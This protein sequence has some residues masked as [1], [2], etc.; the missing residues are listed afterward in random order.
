MSIPVPR[1][2]I[3]LLAPARPP[4]WAAASMPSARPETM[5]SP[6][7]L[8]ARE[9]LRVALALGTRVAASDDRERRARGQLDATRGVK[10]CRRIGDLEQ[11]ARVGFVGERDDRMAGRL[12]PLE[13]AFDRLAHRGGI[14]RAESVGRRERRQL[15]TLF[16][17]DGLRQA[18]LLEHGAQTCRAEPGGERG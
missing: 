12:R 3:V 16:L 11:G 4:R 17:E 14:E 1:T 13:A 10:Q 5:V 2:A 18:E 7:S 8:R 9:A 15:G 6:A